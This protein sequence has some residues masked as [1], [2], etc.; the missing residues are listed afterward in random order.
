MAE[1]AWIFLSHSH[2]DYDKVA[3]V[4]NYLEQQGHHPLMFFLRCLSDDHEVDGL[5]RREI[6]ARSW[7]VL[8]SSANSKKSKWVESEVEIIK[9]LP[10]KTYSEIDLDDANLN[11]DSRLFALTHKASVFLCF[12]HFERDVARAIR[13][14]LQANDFGVF[15]DLDSLFDESWEQRISEE[16]ATAAR[17]GAVLVLLSTRT[18]NH[19]EGWFYWELAQALRAETVQAGHTNIIP[20]YLDGF[21]VRSDMPEKLAN[22][23]GLDFSKE[24]FETNMRVLMELLRS[25]EWKVE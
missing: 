6:E 5:I 12:S 20:I 19:R 3:Q 4:R 23:Y 7:F 9:A 8:C 13:D 14:G 24:D 22:I 25:F 11:L 17:R 21:E 18:L 16:I 1:G 2:Q 10:E 15:S